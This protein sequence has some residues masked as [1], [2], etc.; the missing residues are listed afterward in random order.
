[1]GA[2]TSSWKP[3]CLSLFGDARL[4]SGSKRN[5]T[6]PLRWRNQPV[7]RSEEVGSGG[8]EGEG[9]GALM[10]PLLRPSPHEVSYAGFQKLLVS[11]LW[12]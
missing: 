9:E 8:R 11:V 3:R 10:K 4:A 2:T 6:C 5:L 1:M 7:S 12:C